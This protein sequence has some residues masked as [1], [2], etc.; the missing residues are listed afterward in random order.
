MLPPPFVGARNNHWLKS[1]W[2]WKRN[3]QLQLYPWRLPWNTIMKV[4]KMIFLFNWVICMFRLFIFQGVLC[5]I[6]GAIRVTRDDV[7]SYEMR[8]PIESSKSQGSQRLGNFK[9][10][11]SPLKFDSF[12]PKF[13]AG[14]LQKETPI[15]FQGLCSLPSFWGGVSWEIGANMALGGSAPLLP[16]NWRKHGTRSYHGWSTPTPVRFIRV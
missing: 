5:D 2:I 3:L 15:L 12:F 4:W 1:D 16:E 13:K 8:N 9:S 10:L 7:F 14:W 11:A 6:G